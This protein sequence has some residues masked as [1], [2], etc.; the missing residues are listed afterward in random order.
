M[1]CDKFEFV[2]CKV[3]VHLDEKVF[4]I[5]L[6]RIIPLQEDNTHY[7]NTGCGVFKWGIQN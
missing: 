6:L 7:G 2:R 4:Q 3:E 5:Q 1:I